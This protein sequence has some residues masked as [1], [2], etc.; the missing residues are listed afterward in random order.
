MEGPFEH[1]G[2][3]FCEAVS[4]VAL[5][6]WRSSLYLYVNGK[7]LSWHLALKS[8]TGSWDTSA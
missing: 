5:Q 2:G 4:F 7:T 3:E 8:P 6:E 1:F